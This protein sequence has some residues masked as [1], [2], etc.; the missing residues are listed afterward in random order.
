VDVVPPAQANADAVATVVD[1]LVDNAVKYAPDGR[2]AVAVALREGAVELRVSDDGV[3][4][5]A[6]QAEH[7]FDKFW[8]AD[9]SDARRF[10]GTGIGLYIVRSLVEAMGGTITVRSSLGAGTEFTVRLATSAATPP[11]AQHIPALP[12]QRA[13]EASMIRE[14]MR[15][16]GVADGSDR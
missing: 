7:C 6:E 15:Q 11:A 9:A 16:I 1:H 5:D 12:E 14:F 4:M 8:Q 13:G 3:G 10:G 2:V